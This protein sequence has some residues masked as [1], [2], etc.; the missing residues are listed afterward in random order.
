MKK[1]ILSLVITTLLVITA[2]AAVT[3]VMST[4][5]KVSDPDCNQCVMNDTTRKCGKPNCGGF[6]ASVDGTTKV[7][8]S[9]IKSD[10]KCKKCGHTITYKNK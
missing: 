10:Y 4:W 6:M 8:G 5:V 3:A 2:S 7:E 1:K 9:Y